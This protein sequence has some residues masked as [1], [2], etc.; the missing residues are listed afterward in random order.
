MYKITFDITY[1]EVKYVV[2]WGQLVKQDNT[3]DGN[4]NYDFMKVKVG[5]H[6]TTCREHLDMFDTYEDMCEAFPDQIENI[7]PIELIG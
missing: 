4:I 2:I 1:T 5:D 6:T 7:P 3:L